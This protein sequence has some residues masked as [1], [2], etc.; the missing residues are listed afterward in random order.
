MAS[1]YDTAK[2]NTEALHPVRLLVGDTVAPM[3]LTDEEIDYFLQQHGLTKTTDPDTARDGVL[4]AASRAAR[5]IEAR[6]AKESNVLVMHEGGAVK[7]SAAQEYRK[8]AA[9]LEERANGAA[10]PSFADPTAYPRTFVAGV[11]CEPDLV[12]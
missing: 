5:A 1:T 10:Q 11:D 3:K 7:T 2:L 6:L 4:L 8:L 9:E 12:T